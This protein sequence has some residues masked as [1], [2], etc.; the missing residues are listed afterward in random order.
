M[1]KFI[2][3]YFA[4]SIFFILISLFFLNFE[5][6]HFL[7]NS[8]F[9]YDAIVYKDLA[10]GLYDEKYRETID[11]TNT[12][13]Y[14]PHTS[15]LIYPLISGFIKNYLDLELIYSMFYL[16]LASTYLVTIISYFLINK[17]VNNSFI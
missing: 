8:I 5:N 9:P 2:I 1:N 3:N 14:H 13:I 16:N 17:I 11:Y 7:H 6:L 10:L 12:I 15:K 4:L